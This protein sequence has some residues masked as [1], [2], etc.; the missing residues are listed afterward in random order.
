MNIFF[1]SWLT[2]SLLFLM[3]ESGNPGLFYFI[4]FAGGSVFAAAVSLLLPQSFFYQGLSFLIASI[5]SFVGLRY[6]VAVRSK[7]HQPHT[8]TNI[9]ALKG[10]RVQVIKRI[11]AQEPGEV[12]IRGEL[13]MARTELDETIEMGEW[14]IIIGVSGA[15]VIVVRDKQTH[16]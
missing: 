15:S 12:K 4:S 9:Y 5:I 2:L 14:V 3:F 7:E 8:D 1:F 13:W 11:T 16:R 6:W 10:L